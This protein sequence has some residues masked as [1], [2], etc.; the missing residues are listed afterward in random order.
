MAIADASAYS[1]TVP[2]MSEA[3]DHAWDA[4]L[5]ELGARDAIVCDPVSGGARPWTRAMSGLARELIQDGTAPQEVELQLH[6]VADRDVVEDA[7]VRSEYL[8]A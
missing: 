7:E 8:E 3:I 2:A 6:E 4:A 5:D 1:S